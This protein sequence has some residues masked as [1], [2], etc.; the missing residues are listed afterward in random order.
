MP[1]KCQRP[2]CTNLVK[3]VDDHFCSPAHYRDDKVEQLREKREKERAATEP[4]EA[5]IA[6]AKRLLKWHGLCACVNCDGSC[7]VKAR[8]K[9]APKP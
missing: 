1:R 7:G 3:N 4:T 2:G 6:K 5:N 9:R 8:K